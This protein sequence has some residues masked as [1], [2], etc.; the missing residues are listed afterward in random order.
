METETEIAADTYWAIA[1]ALQTEAGWSVLEHVQYCRKLMQEAVF[2]FGK[3]G[4]NADTAHPNRALWVKLRRCLEGIAPGGDRQLDREICDCQ[5]PEP[6]DG[7]ALV[8]MSCPIHNDRPRS[9]AA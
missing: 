3:L 5:N 8:S 6:A 2:A 9:S 4:A 7:V 1:E